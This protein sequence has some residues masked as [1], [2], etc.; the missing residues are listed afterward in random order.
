MRFFYSL[1]H[2]FKQSPLGINLKMNTSCLMVSLKQWLGHP[3]ELLIFQSYKIS[4]FG[5]KIL[6]LNDVTLPRI[7]LLLS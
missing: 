3:V 6:V 7:V 4:E 2:S 1:P 5:N